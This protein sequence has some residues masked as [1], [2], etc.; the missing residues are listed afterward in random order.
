MIPSEITSSSTDSSSAEEMDRIQQIQTETNL[1]LTDILISEK[2]FSDDELRIIFAEQIQETIQEILTWPKSQYKF[3]I[4]SQVLQGVNSFGSLK[5]EGLLM[6]S[7]RRIDEFPELERIFPSED[8]IVKRLPTPADAT[9]RA[10]RA[11]GIDLRPSRDADEHRRDRSEGADGALLHVRGAEE[12]SRKGAPPDHRGPK[13]PRKPTPETTDA[14]DEAPP[15]RASPVRRSPPWGCSS[16]ASRSASSPCRASSRRDGAF[17]R[18]G[19][20]ARGGGAADAAS[21]APTLGEL[22]S[23]LLEAAVREGLEE[24]LALKG[25]YPTS[26]ETLVANGLMP[27]RMLDEAHARGFSYRAR[28]RREILLARAKSVLD[29][30]RE[31]GEGVYHSPLE[32]LE[33][34]RQARPELR[35]DAPDGIDHVDRLAPQREAIGPRAATAA[36]RA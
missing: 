27:K 25:A 5:V 31:N 33:P 21:V 2:K 26:L 24:H 28:E 1:D 32:I 10:R 14:E 12:P 20:V 6:E 7:M 4:G 22:E 34:E 15:R 18:R 29:E 23:R 30:R 36:D 9:V 16:S 35:L 8:T 11:R 17:V 13:E 19:A 3:I